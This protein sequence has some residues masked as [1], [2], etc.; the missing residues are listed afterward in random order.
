MANKKKIVYLTIDTG[1]DGREQVIIDASY[2]EDVR[3]ERFIK[4]INSDRLMKSERI[5]NPENEKESAL[6]ELNALQKLVLGLTKDP[7]QVATR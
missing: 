6:I 1:V 7:V 5:I 3:D 2:D 4:F